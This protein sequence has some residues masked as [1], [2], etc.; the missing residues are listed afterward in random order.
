MGESE[1]AAE[2]EPG[3]HEWKEAARVG[4]PCHSEDGIHA[5]EGLPAGGQPLQHLR[6]MEGGACACPPLAGLLHHDR[7][8]VDAVRLDALLR[9]AGEGATGAAADLQDAPGTACPMG[10]LRPGERED[11]GKL[12]G[13][14]GTTA[15]RSC[16]CWRPR[17]RRSRSGRSGRL[18]SGP[19]GAGMR[20]YLGRDRGRRRAVCT[21]GP[22]P[23]PGAPTRSGTPCQ[24]VPRFS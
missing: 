10:P 5:V 9:Q 15:R 6:A 7:G 17:P 18:H 20:Y 4:E 3:P 16:R 11:S 24:P 19:S 23:G 13:T 14:P 21:R 22:S 12:A 2:V 8:E 1:D